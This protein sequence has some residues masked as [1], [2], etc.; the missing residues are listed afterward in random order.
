MNSRHKNN[1][2]SFL[3]MLML[4]GII[5]G[6]FVGFFE[7]YSSRNQSL[8][9]S[10]RILKQD[11][12]LKNGLHFL[13]I[14]LNKLTL[15][16]FDSSSFYQLNPDNNILKEMTES[17]EHKNLL[18]S[19]IIKTRVEGYDLKYVSACIPIEKALSI[20]EVSY[21]KLI[22]NDLW[23]F[24][25]ELN[26]SYGVHCCPKD[27]PTCQLNN[28]IDEDSKYVVQIF[29]YDPNMNQLKPILKKAEF[30]SVSSAGFFV[31]GNKHHENK[32]HGRFFTF[33]NEC[34]SQKIIF[35]KSS[36]N[37]NQKLSFKSQEITQY[38]QK[39]DF[40]QILMSST[41]P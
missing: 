22:K 1:H 4:F 32:I 7:M 3:R 33:F 35:G 13:D 38:L 9:L 17:L 27:Q 29:K 8:S 39:N 24:I 10:K 26:G 16:D 2:P 15:N 19:F 14:H 11:N 37:C 28:V 21:E 5:F 36:K 18:T 40:N 41:T 25:T 30:G 12:Y 34:L 20:N 23:P 6:T 31:F